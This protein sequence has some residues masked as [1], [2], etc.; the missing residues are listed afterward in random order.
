MANIIYNVG[1]DRI[2]EVDKTLTSNKA[3]PNRRE[4]ISMLR[5]DL[6]TLKRSYEKATKCEKPALSELQNILRNQLDQVREK[7]RM[8]RKKRARRKAQFVT[9]PHHAMCKLFFFGMEEFYSYKE[10]NS[11]KK[12]KQG[13]KIHQHNNKNKKITKYIYIYIYIYI[14][15]YI[16]II[17][18]YYTDVDSVN[19]IF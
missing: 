18:S 15:I 6:N 7:S 1:K 13:N 5:S 11:T 9:N 14:C 3:E 12:T 16:Y 17:W 10:K 8:R 19:F 4:K 2:G